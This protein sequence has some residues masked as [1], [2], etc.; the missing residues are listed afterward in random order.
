MSVMAGLPAGF[1]NAS[2]TQ[3]PCCCHAVMLGKDTG[4][5]VEGTDEGRVEDVCGV[6]ADMGA[7]GRVGEPRRE[8]RGSCKF[9]LKWVLSKEVGCVMEQNVSISG[10]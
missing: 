9:R 7:G 2:A 4:V 10:L 6:C 1:A 8:A 3:Q 5:G